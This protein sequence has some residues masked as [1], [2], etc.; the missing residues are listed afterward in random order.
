M[1]IPQERAIHSLEGA[2]ATSTRPAITM[3]LQDLLLVMPI[4]Q[5]AEISSSAAFAG[6]SNTIENENS[7]LGYTAN[8]AA[9]IT[10]ATAIGAKAS[11]TQSNSLVLGSING[12]NSA[13]ASVNVGIGTTAPGAPLE[14][15]RDG[16]VGSNWQT[17]QLRISGSSDPAMQL[18]L[19]YDTTSNLGVIQPG[20]AGFAFKNLSLNPSGG[21]VG[22]GTVSPADR[23]DVNGIIRVSTLGSAGSTQLCRNAANQI[24]TCSSSLRYKNQIRPFTF[25]LA[26]INRLRP[27]SF[28][29]IAGGERD[30]GLVAEEV[31]EVEPLLVTTNDKGQVEGVKYDRINVALVNAVKEL[32][33]EK[34]AQM[35]ALK[36]E[37]RRFNSRTR[38]R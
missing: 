37:N 19:G 1:R 36:A 35:A 8:G 2:P 25:G 9:G 38:R 30:L 14:L 29:W 12:I 5:E 7:F 28:N 15:R 34:D 24:S 32:R 22:V 17:A 16:N 10:N 20:H 21:N 6:A 27:V 18:N 33:A 31:A 26:L 4:P 11:V 13:T 3:C 23:L